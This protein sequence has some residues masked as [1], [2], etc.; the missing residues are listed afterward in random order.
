MLET[1][2][3]SCKSTSFKRSPEKSARRCG[4]IW[5]PGWPKKMSKC[6]PT[7]CLTRG[8]GA[9]DSTPSSKTAPI[10]WLCRRYLL[11]GHETHSLVQT[12]WHGLTEP[13]CNLVCVLYSMGTESS[14]RYPGYKWRERAQEHDDDQ[15]KFNNQL[16]HVIPFFLCPQRQVHYWIF[17]IC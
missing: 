4:K 2:H 10:P 12:T 11:C 9:V 13:S 7:R 5:S 1:K 17:K 14:C 15:E 16:F 6:D 3:S 8:I